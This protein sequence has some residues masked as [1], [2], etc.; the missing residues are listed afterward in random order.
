M[1]DHEY[2]YV[3][4]V[5]YYINLTVCLWACVCVPNCVCAHIS[6]C[7]CVLYVCMSERLGVRDSFNLC[8]SLSVCE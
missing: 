3:N 5:R 4:E 1:C 7:V 8:V 6:L 2:P